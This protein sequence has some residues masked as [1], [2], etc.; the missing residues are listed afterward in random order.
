MGRW[1]WALLFYV[2]SLEAHATHSQLNAFKIDADSMSQTQLARV[3]E[4][5]TEV[6]KTKIGNE[7]LEKIE[8]CGNTVYLRHKP[9]SLAAGGTTEIELSRKMRN[10]EGVDAHIA[11]HLGIPDSGSHV[12]YDI[13]H[14]EISFN[15][16][17]NF[18]HELAHARHAACG[19]LNIFNT[20][21]QAIADENRFRLERANA[22]GVPA[23]K[24][25][26]VEGKQIW[27][28]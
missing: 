9:E 25:A 20:E 28:P 11:M 1:I 10:G 22:L 17:E 21:G 5:L 12:V 3:H 27:Y 7:T 15:A 6:A 23:Q 8:S 19:T 14:N 26:F 2:L 24:R 16:L 4:W 13:N 18:F